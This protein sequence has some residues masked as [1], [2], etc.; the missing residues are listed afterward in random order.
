M[1]WLGGQAIRR[2]LLSCRAGCVNDPLRQSTPLP[3]RS[4]ARSA[5]SCTS[6]C[7]R[8]NTRPPSSL[9]QGDL[10]PN[11]APPSLGVAATKLHRVMP[12]RTAQIGSRHRDGRLHTARAPAA[13]CGF[14]LSSTMRP[15][16]HS[17]GRP[18]LCWWVGTAPRCKRVVA[19]VPRLFKTPRPTATWSPHDWVRGSHRWKCAVPSLA[20]DVPAIRAC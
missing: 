1:R 9:A 15:I 20:S 14:P 5:A 7:C 16:I 4:T 12:P 6:R 10:E 11:S 3:S 2:S 13:T 17:H 18:Q 8:R 19:R